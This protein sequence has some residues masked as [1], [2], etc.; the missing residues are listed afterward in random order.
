MSHTPPPRPPVRTLLLA[1]GG[2]TVAV[3]LAAFLASSLSTLLLMGS[4]GATCCL[5]FGFPDG[6][7]SQP[8]AVVGGHLFSVVVGLAALHWAGPS[9]LSV[10]LAVG[11]ATAGMMALRITHPPAA[12]NPVIVFLGK[13]AWGFALFPALAGALVIVAVA[14]VWNN[15]VRKVRYPLYW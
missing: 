3:A 5:V 11:I 2:C 6:P 8:R 7:F 4:L 9:A 15:G 12:S 13:S 14:L 10:G 1:L